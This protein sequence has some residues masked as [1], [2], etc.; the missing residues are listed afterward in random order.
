MDVPESEHGLYAATRGDTV[1][2]RV[3]GPGVYSLGPVLKHFGAVCADEGCAT[4]VLDLAEC[5]V[6]DSTFLGVVAGLAMK[7][8]RRPGGGRVLLVGAAER[9][10]ENLR[11]L[12]LS[13]MAPLLTPADAARELPGLVWDPAAMR[14]ID[15]HPPPDKRLTRQTMLEAHE[16]LSTLSEANAEVFKNVLAVLRDSERQTGA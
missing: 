16:N 6:V 7:F 4:L 9:I 15:L 5:E 1:I 3:R 13:Q 11:T 14:R 12:G 2:L 10:A 8:R